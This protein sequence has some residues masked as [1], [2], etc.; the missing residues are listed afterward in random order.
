MADDTVAQ[1]VPLAGQ[2]D[3]ELLEFRDPPVDLDELS[4][5]L[6]EPFL[7]CREIDTLL[8]PFGQGLDE[9]LEIRDRLVESADMDLDRV[10]VAVESRLAH[11]DDVSLRSRSCE[12]T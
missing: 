8:N 6:L 9:R 3:V 10:N 2:S 7:R 12:D 4:L 1:P 5:V 11:H